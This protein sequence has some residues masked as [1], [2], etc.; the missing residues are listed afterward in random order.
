MEEIKSWWAIA[1]QIAPGATFILGIVVVA[2]WR[3]RAIE[4]EYARK[5]DIDDAER[6]NKIV[7]LLE[8][9]ALNSAQCVKAVEES[10][11]RIIEH[12]NTNF[13]KTR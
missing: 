7:L 5:R 2:L 8:K 11:D 12:M 10:R 13:K 3:E 6:M 4:R 1:Q 9:E